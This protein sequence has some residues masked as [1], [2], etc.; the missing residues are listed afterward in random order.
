MPISKIFSFIYPNWKI[1]LDRRVFPFFFILLLFI[2]LITLFIVLFPDQQNKLLAISAIIPGITA[3]LMPF[4]YDF[5]G[6]LNRPI[7]NLKFEHCNPY[8]RKLAWEPFKKRY[9][10]R[11]KEFLVYKIL[12]N[13]RILVCNSGKTTA[14][15]VVVRIEKIEF[16]EEATNNLRIDPIHYHP[17]TVKWSGEDDYTPV[18]I[19]P[20]SFFF[21]DLIRF[22]NE[23]KKD[24]VDFNYQLY[25]KKIPR[26]FFEKII[27]E[28]KTVE[29]PYWSVWIK[30]AFLRGLKETYFEQ[31]KFI[32]YYILNSENSSNIK[33][34]AEIYWNRSEWDNPKVLIRTI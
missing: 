25:Q 6:F 1:L 20:N 24:L 31:G 7:I 12:C 8:I 28:S 4:F 3:L 34:S 17:T 21:L 10:L 15:N 19:L 18:D 9:K 14:K 33:F 5:L 29:K 32:I 2:V 11:S 22:V 27:F 23:Q 13:I 16:Y 30:N 26:T